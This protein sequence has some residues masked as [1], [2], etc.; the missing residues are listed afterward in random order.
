[1]L[2]RRGFVIAEGWWGPYRSDRPHMLFSLSKSFTS[3][4][5]GFVVDEGLI[6]VDDKVCDFFPEQRPTKIGPNLARME[7][8]HLLSMSTGHEED[9]TG[10]VISARGGDWAKAFLS[11]DVEREPGT[12]FV[13]NTAA[14]YMLAAI[15][16][17]VTGQ[18]LIDYLTPRLLNPLG[19]EGA[20]WE[21]CPKGINT[22]G[23][24]LSI[25]TADIARFGQLYLQK[26]VWKGQRLISQ[27]WISEATRKQISNGNDPLSDWNQGYGYQFWRCQHDA[28]RGDGAF[29]QFCVV[30]SEE[31]LVVAITAGLNDMQ[32]VLDGIWSI[33]LPAL[34]PVA[35]PE[36][37]AEHE[38]LQIKLKE[39]ALPTLPGRKRDNAKELGGRYVFPANDLG[40]KAVTLKFDADACHVMLELSSGKPK[41]VFGYGSYMQSKFRY[42]RSTTLA[43]SCASWKDDTT[44]ELMSRLVETPF[45][46]TVT[47][48]FAPGQI[49]LQAS[50]NCSFGPREFPV[51][52]GRLEEAESVS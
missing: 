50:V 5:I 13:Y 17:N 38:R 41:V 8:R 39:L 28:Y 19:I 31:E 45:T 26:G 43:L 29:G 21:T 14:T 18:N 32:G 9:T 22:G 6:A 27:E 36:N 25:K 51:V 3:T 46:Y 49:E 15:L 34:S 10:R 35:L 37:R 11:L 16:H 42:Q 12:H 52:R 48:G 33:L 23:F 40:I 7:I 44:L 30:V 20:T 1:M 2:L 47:C 24:G 4:A